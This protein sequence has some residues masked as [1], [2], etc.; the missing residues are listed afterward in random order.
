MEAAMAHPTSL[1]TK[2]QWS[3]RLHDW[4][5]ERWGE[6]RAQAIGGEIEV[7][8]EHLFTV[9]AYALAMEQIPGFFMEQ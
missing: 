3:A 1:W 6:A 4:A 5:V 8:A 7:T 2:E 9:S